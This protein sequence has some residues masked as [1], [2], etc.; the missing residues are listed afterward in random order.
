MAEVAV[1]EKLEILH[2]H[3]AIPHAISA[4]LAKQILGSTRLK[5]ITTLHGT[6]IT[7][8]GRDESYLPITKFGIE[9]SDG[10]TAVSEWLREETASNFDTKKQIEVIPNFVDPVR[11]R[12]D[13]SAC[14]LFGI[15]NEKLICH[16][17]NFRPVKRIMDVL[18][19]FERVS[20]VIPSRLVMIGDGP[21][22][23][24]AEAF[25]REHRL[26]DRVFFLGN[27]PNL[28]EILG[29]A[30]SFGLPAAA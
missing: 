29:A 1:Y 10:V 20:R 9:I 26:R 7:L 14:A 30:N 17:S 23:S 28:E 5:V 21:D 13:S 8:V 16:V 24:R 22:R 11:F 25:C 19:I 3:Y 12:R 4:H 18:A 2:V 27:V 15:S 6:D